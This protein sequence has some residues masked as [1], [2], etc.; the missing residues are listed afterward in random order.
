MGRHPCASQTEHPH[1]CG[2][3]RLAPDLPA[4]NRASPDGNDAP[5]HLL[6]VLGH[7]YRAKYG[8]F[9]ECRS[10]GTRPASR[11]DVIGKEYDVDNRLLMQSLGGSQQDFREGVKQKRYAV[12]LNPE[13]NKPRQ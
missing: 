3:G 5:F 12:P 8:H 4:G 9:S 11:L 13:A 10:V 6:V 1:L 7:F 2:R